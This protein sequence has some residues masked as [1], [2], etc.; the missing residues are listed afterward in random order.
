[1]VIGWLGLLTLA[2]IALSALVI[3]LFRISGI[4]GG[5]RLGFGEAFWQ[6]LLRVVDAGTFAGDSGW[7]TRSLGLLITLAGI[8]LAGSLIG[9][10]ANGVDQRIA[11][12]RKGRSV[13]IEDDHTLILG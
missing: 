6:S 2:I 10:I 5:E 13:V 12:L 3:T 11:Q 1:V 8:F 4:N 9:L 7:L